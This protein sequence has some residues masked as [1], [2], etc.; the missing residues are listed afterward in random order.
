MSSCLHL[1]A[2]SPSPVISSPCHIRSLGFWKC[3]SSVVTPDPNQLTAVTVLGLF[4]GQKALVWAAANP[5]HFTEI[6][7]T[8]LFIS[9][10]QWGRGTSYFFD[11]LMSCL[12]PR[13]SGKAPQL[14]YYKP[15][16][17]KQNFFQTH[18]TITCLRNGRA[19]VFLLYMFS[20]Y[21]GIWRALLLGWG[22]ECAGHSIL[23]VYQMADG[24]SLI[25]PTE[26]L[27][28]CGTVMEPQQ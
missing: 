21:P 23:A 7:Q 14:W 1:F 10:A 17:V 20:S 26:A 18:L 6:T 25:W 16:P 8:M 28:F 9:A 19:L 4:P 27:V 3:E 11:Q 15:P 13:Q 22:Q 2:P 24:L 12:S 5:L